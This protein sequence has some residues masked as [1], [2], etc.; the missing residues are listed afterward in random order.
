MKKYVPFVC[1]LFL[2]EKVSSWVEKFRAYRKK[3]ITDY[4]SCN[5]MPHSPAG[6]ACWLVLKILNKRTSKTATIYRFPLRKRWLRDTLEQ[7][8]IKL[9]ELQ[10]KGG[11]LNKNL[12]HLGN[13][14]GQMTEICTMSGVLFKSA[15][16]NIAN[17]DSVVSLMSFLDA[18]RTNLGT[19]LK[20]DL[21]FQINL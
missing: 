7:I 3:L 13:A 9:Y 19:R 11:T 10:S 20:G 8:F 18:I 5:V 4:F 1:K 6:Q 17:N 14:L 2:V 15:H 12:K 21:P 16:A